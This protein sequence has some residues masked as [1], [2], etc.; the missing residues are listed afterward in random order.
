MAYTTIDNPGLFFNTVIYAGNGSARSITGVG[1]QT[2]WSWFKNRSATNGHSMFDSVRGATKNMIPNTTAAESTSSNG[3]TAFASDGFSVG[4]DGDVNANGNNIVSWNWKAGTAFSNDASA[5]G[6]GTIDSVGSI[7]TTAGFSIC[8]W[9]GNSGTI[10][11]GLGVKPDVI[12]I[13]SRQTVN[14]WV[15]LHKNL[16]GGMDTNALIL[17]ATDAEQ[18]GGAGM[19]EPTSSVFTITAGLAANDNN[20]G[21]LFAEKK[22]FSKFGKYTGNGNVDGPFTYTGFKPAFFMTKRSDVA[23]SWVM[24][25]NT[26]D[27][28]NEVTKNIYANASDAE[29]TDSNNNDLDFLSNGVKIREDNNAIN[30]SGGTYVYMAFAESPFVTAGT[31]AAGTAR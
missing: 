10:A 11:H 31:K 30:A 26:R 18:G 22:G 24:F 19:A 13:K 12:W 1:F 2:D 15:V 6:I 27:P 17:N 3:L 4:T 7:S 16:T 5:T 8:S 9:T 25:D 20:I 14:N 28:N 21:Y 23:N 29:E